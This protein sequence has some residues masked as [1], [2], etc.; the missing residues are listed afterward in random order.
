MMTWPWMAERA[1][2]LQSA[3]TEAACTQTVHTTENYHNFQTGW[4]AN[5]NAL[6]KIIREQ[7]K[8]YDFFG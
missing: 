7:A 8:Q 2:D 1:E 6:W 3:Q 4:Q 5:K